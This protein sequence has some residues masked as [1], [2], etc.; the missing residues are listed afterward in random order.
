LARHLNSVLFTQGEL[1]KILLL[2]MMIGNSFALTSSEVGKTF[3][4]IINAQEVA[5]NRMD[6]ESAAQLLPFGFQMN[7]MV[8][9]ISVSKSGPMGISAL[10]SNTAVE[11]KWRRNNL[12]AE[13]DAADYVVEAESTEKDIAQLADSIVNVVK[14]SGKVKNDSVLRTNVVHALNTVREQMM[15][16]EV[17]RLQQWKAN[18]LRLDLNFST[19]GEVWFIARAGVALRLRMEWKLKERTLK[20]ADSTMI[21]PQ[22]RF[23]VKTLSGLNQAVEKVPLKG[24]EVKKIMIGVGQSKARKFWGPWKYSAGMIGWLGFQQVTQPYKSIQAAVPIELLNEDFIIGGFESSETTE[25]G[26]W[27]WSRRR[28]SRTSFQ[29]G[30]EQ[31]LR[32][33]AFYAERAMLPKRG[34]W[35]VSEIK[36]KNDISHTGFFGLANVS[37]RG[38]LEIDLRRK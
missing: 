18:V 19:H 2:F 24:F 11:I 30:L 26:I 23:V 21:N 28:I 14:I 17:T 31:S 35:H 7:E 13:E 15:S 1:I 27:P 3:D 20:N 4:Q 5:L 16:F 22:T 32:T 33:A 25:K 8:T 34:Q 37:T 36:T 38:I 29:S 9:D 12:D 10:K 6:E